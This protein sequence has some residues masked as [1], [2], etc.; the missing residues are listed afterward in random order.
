MLKSIRFYGSLFFAVFAVLSY[1]QE[2]D[3]PWCGGDGDL[4]HP[5]AWTVLE[6]QIRE[7]SSTDLHGRRTSL[8]S[9]NLKVKLNYMK[10][11]TRNPLTR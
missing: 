3:P 5:L 8:F 10:P 2:V 4:E 6:P 1:A 9:I 7:K 11:P